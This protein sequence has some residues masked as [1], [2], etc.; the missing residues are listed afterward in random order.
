MLERIRCDRCHEFRE[1][2]IELGVTVGCYD[3]TEGSYWSC[4]ARGDERVICESCIREEPLYVE[5][6]GTHR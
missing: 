2:F 6:Y 4:F 5:L 1:G 3:V